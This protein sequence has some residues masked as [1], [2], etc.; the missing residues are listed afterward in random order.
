MMVASEGERY[1]LRM[2]KKASR[3]LTTFQMNKQIGE[4]LSW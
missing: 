4:K 1:R 3:P 2:E